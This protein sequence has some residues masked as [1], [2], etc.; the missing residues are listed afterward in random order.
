MAREVTAMKEDPMNVESCGDVISRGSRSR[1]ATK[2]L[3]LAGIVAAGVYVV[4]DLLSGLV[5]NV[6][7]PYSFRDQWISELTA[8][9][10]PV[11]PLMVTVITIH[12]VLLIAF[13]AGD[14]EGGRSDQEPALGGAG[15]DR[16]T[17]LGLVIHPIFPMASRWSFTDTPM[18]GSLSV[19][20]GLIISVAVALSAVAHRGWFRLFD[21]DARRDDRLRNGLRDRHPRDRAERH[22]VGRSL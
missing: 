5:Y 22:A 15:P 9:G 21:R 19:V 6:S 7:R 10:S 14:L 8:T 18:H 11:R 12:D 16:A 4:G 20:W 2:A 3:L 17:A 13:R 1:T